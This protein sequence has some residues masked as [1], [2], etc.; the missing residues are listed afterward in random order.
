M[1]CVECG[2]EPEKLYDSLCEECYGKRLQADIDEHL[3][4]DVCT[5]CWA[6]RQ[7]HTWKERPD[8]N[9][10]ML[11]RIDRAIS[12]SPEVSRYS[13]RVY[14]I[15]EDP[16]NYLARI[17]VELISNDIKVERDIST[18]IIFK[19]VQCKTCSRIHGNYYEAILQVRPRSREMRAD[20][21]AL[22]KEMVKREVEERRGGERNIF[23]TSSEEIHGGLDFYLSDNGVAKK[24][25]KEISNVF[26]GKV[27]SSSSLAGRKD[28]RNIYKMTYS[29]RLP[30][31]ERGDFLYLENELYRVI[32]I[33]TSS[34]HVTL[35]HVET[36]RR[37]SMERRELE[38]VDVLGSDELIKEA[39]KV[40]ENDKEMKILDPDTYQ[41]V[42]LLKPEGFISGG[43][44]VKVV[45]TP[46]RLL[47]LP[48]I[49]D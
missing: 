31:Y 29:V 30:P 18:R 43:D 32:E 49:D 46:D 44:Y 13:F 17:K 24:L 11:E 8:M 3:D 21:K 6:V 27:I 41:T 26:G 4:I 37:I 42:T 7:G 5:S 33:G 16:R 38:D 28:G 36:G 34:G 12:I 23:I 40:S 1:F 48:V 15:E 35:T 9:S 47:L 22:V 25:S 10:I 2:K 20:Q 19:K 39:V 45:K 14:F